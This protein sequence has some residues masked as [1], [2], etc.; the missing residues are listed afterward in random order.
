M[1]N[2][3]TY[4]IGELRTLARTNPAYAAALARMEKPEPAHVPPPMRVEDMPGYVSP[5]KKAKNETGH[6][7]Q[8]PDSQPQ[9]KPRPALEQAVSGKTKGIPRV[10]VRI[11][12]FRVRPLDPDNFAGSTKDAI[13]GLRH[14]GLIPGDEPWRI[15]LET[16]QE[17]VATFAE[18]KT[19]IEIES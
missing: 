8:I 16:E 11:T 12:G 17:K 9:P 6:H 15:K 2:G 19:V 13:D 5:P 4:T 10:T 3:L 7:R 1:S 18:E 14:A